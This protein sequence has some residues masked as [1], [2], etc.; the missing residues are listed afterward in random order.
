[1]LCAAV[2]NCCLLGSSTDLSQQE[3]VVATNHHVIPAACCSWA[4]SVWHAPIKK[5]K[6]SCHLPSSS[7]H[8]S[9]SNHSNGPP[10]LL[11][12]NR[13]H[14]YWK[15]LRER[16]MKGKRHLWIYLYRWQD[17]VRVPWL[18]ICSRNWG[19]AAWSMRHLWVF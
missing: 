14:N 11:K 5:F 17:R 12:N 3:M 13:S 6:W 2:D 9:C 19:V 10:R 15:G 8:F 16:D 1:M 18:Q 4:P 7:P